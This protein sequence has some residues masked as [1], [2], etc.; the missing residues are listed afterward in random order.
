MGPHCATATSWS[1]PKKSSRK[2]RDDM[3]ISTQSSR[4]KQALALSA[5]VQK[6][7][8]LVEVILRQSRKVLRHRPGVLIVEH[9]L[10]FVLA[11]AGVDQSNVDPRQGAKP[12]LLLPED[13][14]GSARRLH[15]GIRSQLGKNIA[16]IINDSLGRAWRLGTVGVALGRPACRRCPIF[17]AGRTLRPPAQGERNGFRGRNRSGGIAA[18][19]T[20][21]RSDADRCRARP[22]V[23]REGIVGCALVARSR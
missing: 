2:Q 7:A 8:R 4:A 23:V 17:A 15:E 19:G 12:V 9:K 1:L 11:N 20:G 14:D 21:G 22:H 5:Q 6:D 10:G 18:D 16:V 13:P 3:S